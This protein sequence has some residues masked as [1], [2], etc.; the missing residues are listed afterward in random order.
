MNKHLV[1]THE[2]A[3]AA[4]LFDG[5][6]SAYYAVDPR[7]KVRYAQFFITVAQSLNTDVLTRFKN[8]VSIGKVNGPYYQGSARKPIYR[9]TCNGFE[10]SQ[11]IVCLLW[12]YL[13]SPK[14]QQILNALNGY[15]NRKQV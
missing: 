3:W 13:S 14:K 7:Y 2:L 9:Y 12:K 5:E 1:D 15:H 4:G 10:H 6:G 8:A 11:Y